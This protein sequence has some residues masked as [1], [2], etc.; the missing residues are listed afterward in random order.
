MQL[1]NPN[2]LTLLM[3]LTQL[4]TIN[5]TQYNECNS[6]ISTQHKELNAVLTTLRPHLSK[7]FH[8]L[9]SVI[10]FVFKV[11]HILEH[12]HVSNVQTSLFLKGG[13]IMMTLL[14]EWM[15]NDL[16]EL[17]SGW[18]HP[19]NVVSLRQSQ[20]ERIGRRRNTEK[21]WG[22]QFQKH[23]SNTK[24]NYIIACLTWGT[25]NAV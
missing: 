13:F 1:T 23:G 3:Q 4:N 11:L 15:R 10:Q 16:K 19:D 2:T 22:T 14:K 6:H 7:Y 17:E 24:C 8:L 12:T 21:N 9:Y 5:A 20:L 18:S 25:S